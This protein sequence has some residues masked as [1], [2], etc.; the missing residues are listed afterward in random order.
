M[1]SLIILILLMNNA[2]AGNFF[3]D[4][5]KQILKKNEP[6]KPV[7]AT[8]AP[9]APPKDIP[10]EDNL[11]Q[12]MSD[13]FHSTCINQTKENN[14]VDQ[15]TLKRAC[16]CYT[17]EM[18]ETKAISK[19]INESKENSKVDE[20]KL[21]GKVEAYFG[22]NDF[23]NIVN[24]CNG[25]LQKQWDGKLSPELKLE[26]VMKCKE[27]AMKGG[28][29]DGQSTLECYCI[30]DSMEKDGIY[31]KL[32]DQSIDKTTNQV[33]PSLFTLKTIEF[34]SSK[35]AKEII[36]KCKKPNESLP[37]H[38]TKYSNTLNSAISFNSDA[39]I[40]G[41][42]NHDVYLGCLS[43]NKFDS[44]SVHNEFGNYGS[45]FSST[46]IF[47]QFSNYGG[48]FS[49]ESPCNKFANNPPALVTTD[50]KFYGFLTVNGYKDKAIKDQKILNWLNWVVC[51]KN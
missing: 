27:E 1:K 4:L 44:N 48:K 37:K 43:C 23:K 49:D 7:A 33:N 22:S 31:K 16:D 14:N 47:N 3:K 30:I 39:Q 29:S 45:K 51:P 36:N 5:K 2:N 50:G 26:S 10:Q 28:E 12:K 6:A 41:G 40:F 35:E 24:K 21:N 32:A 15:D 18:K 9:V 20:K 34:Y 17:Y 13:M 19:I 38:D 46:S 11:E 8:P 42:R 25:N